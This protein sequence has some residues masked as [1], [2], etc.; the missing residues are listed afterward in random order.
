MARQRNAA[1]AQR[2]DSDRPGVRLVD[3][4]LGTRAVRPHSPVSRLELSGTGRS[5]A[6]S[7]WEIAAASSPCRDQVLLRWGPCGDPHV[8]RRRFERARS[9]RHTSREPGATVRLSFWE[10]VGRGGSAVDDGRV[11]HRPEEDVM[12]S[13]PLPD[14]AGRRRSPATTSSFR[15]GV[16]PS[17]KGVRYPP[18]PP[19]VEEIIAVNARGWRCS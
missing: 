5:D 13:I 17:N 15:Q 8:G 16:A 19:T 7:R 18:D 3:D 2:H 1:A 10:W 9:A 6:K 12:E 4:S 14:R 11:H